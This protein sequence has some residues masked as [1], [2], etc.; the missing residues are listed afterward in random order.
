ME[1]GLHSTIVEYR[2]RIKSQ[3]L[4]NPKSF[5]E[6]LNKFCYK[7]QLNS[8]KLSIWILQVHEK[9]YFFKRKRKKQFINKKCT[10]WPTP[11]LWILK[12][13]DINVLSLISNANAHDRDFLL[14]FDI[15]NL[16]VRTTDERTKN[17]SQLHA[18]T[19]LHFIRFHNRS[20]RLLLT[21]SI[22]V[23]FYHFYCFFFFSFAF[24]SSIF[25]SLPYIFLLLFSIHIA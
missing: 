21:M 2:I 20:H 4:I 8:K 13:I 15:I 1:N 19:T 25:Y 6:Q 17:R 24:F 3:L 18:V 14:V 16:S 22:I 11:G 5:K 7:E 9:F 12:F 23:F 10:S